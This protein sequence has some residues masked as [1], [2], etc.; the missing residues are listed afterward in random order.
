MSTQQMGPVLSG[1]PAGFSHTNAGG[2]P[3]G[4]NSS[5]AA[6]LSYDVGHN[7]P[8]GW[9]V[10]LYTWT[11]GLAAGIYLLAAALVFTGTVADTSPL[12]RFATPVGSG[13]LLGVT[14]A[15][16]IS[17]LKH[18]RRFYM[19]FTHPQWRSWLVRGS[20]IIGAY[21]VVLAIHFL[22]GLIGLTSLL[23]VLSL[24]GV[25]LAAST[26]VYTG[27]LFA[28]AK[29]RDLWQSPLLPP[30][31][32]VQA[33]MVGAA[34]LVP[35]AVI[36]DSAA[37]RV[38]AWVLAFSAAVHLILVLSE[39]TLP[40]VT[41]HAR[42]ARHN[43]VRGRNAAFFWLGG[44]CVATAMLAPALA[45]LAPWLGVLVCPL[46]LVGMLAYEHAYVQAGQSVPLA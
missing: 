35:A 42:L 1:A 38:I 34:A 27:F 13:A 30:H 3:Q 22:A 29:A 15:L 32:L 8:W 25:P 7:L 28:Q 19:I 20:I 16:L 39:T 12:W 33:I 41:A 26:A 46:A 40:D 9:R 4:G 5:A 14:G 18:P 23:S 31:F 45:A 43:M 37:V 36:M 2:Q 44:I 17:D 24:V 10:S 6:L 11:K 21:S